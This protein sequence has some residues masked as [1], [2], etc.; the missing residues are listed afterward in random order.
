LILD[1]YYIHS[2]AARYE[3]HQLLI[4]HRRQYPPKQFLSCK[5]RHML[6]PTVHSQPSTNRTLNLGFAQ[7]RFC[8][9]FYPHKKHAPP[10]P[11]RK[12]FH[13]AKCQN[14]TICGVNDLPKEF[15]RMSCYHYWQN[16]RRYNKTSEQNKKRKKHY[17]TGLCCL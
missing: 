1:N 2:D 9:T 16:V 8:F 17:T 3:K 12:I 15:S 13:R 11:P 6:N 4:S 10:P 7:L 14:P 5:Q